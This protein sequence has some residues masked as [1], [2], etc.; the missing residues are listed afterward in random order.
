VDESLNKY[1]ESSSD[2]SSSNEKTYKNVNLQVSNEVT[3]TNVDSYS[4]SSSDNIGDVTQIDSESS[5]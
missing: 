2:L 4:T 5:Y 1:A 3:A